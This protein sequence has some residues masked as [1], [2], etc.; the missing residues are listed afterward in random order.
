MS[1]DPTQYLKYS[2]ERLRPALDLL[3][4]IPLTAPETD[5]R[6]RLRRGERDGVSRGALAA[7][8]HRRRRQFE[9]NARQGA[10]VGGGRRDARMDRGR[11]CE[12]GRRAS[13]SMWST[14]TRR[15]TGR[16]ITRDCSR[17]SSTG[18]RRAA[19]S[20][21]RCRISSPRRRIVALAEVVA[22]TRWRD[23]LARCAR[24]SPVLPAAGLFSAAGR[25][26][27]ARGCVDDRVSARPAG[28]A[29]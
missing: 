26:R 18:W 5:R 13:R 23:R 17:G 20:P 11:H 16:T 9:G 24:A 15:C 22:A 12:R 10:R 4:R 3:A 2:S 6:S 27:A 19:C 28:V 7:R 25:A 1:W 29:R 14:A 21:C 8:A